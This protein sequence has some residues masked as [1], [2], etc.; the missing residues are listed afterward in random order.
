MDL[1][2]KASDVEQLQRDKA[3]ENARAEI[4]RI[5][6]HPGLTNKGDPENRVL[7]DRL[8]QLYEIAHPADAA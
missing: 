5:R 8:T 4:A 7:N 1:N 2:D 6:S 3:I